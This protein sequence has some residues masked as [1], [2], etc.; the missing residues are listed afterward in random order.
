[1]RADVVNREDV[2]MV[3]RARGLG[4]LFE[5]GE[6]IFIR[7][8]FRRQDL[9]CD[10]PIHLRIIGAIHLAHSALADLCADFVAAEFGADWDHFDERYL[11]NA[12][13]QFVTSVSEGAA[14]VSRGTGNRIRL[15]SELMYTGTSQPPRG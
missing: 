2:R 6:P 15:P 3:E 1:M 9:D 8:N 11:C 10:L 13:V 4:L 7:R 12:A 5:P 14:F